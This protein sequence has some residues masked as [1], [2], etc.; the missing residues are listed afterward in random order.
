MGH[1][2]L[3]PRKPK[4]SATPQQQ[5]PPQPSPQRPA[6]PVVSAPKVRPAKGRTTSITESFLRGFWRG[7]IVFVLAGLF[8]LGAGLISM[9]VIAGP[10]PTWDKLEKDASKFQSLRILDRNGNLLSES[11]D[12]NQGRRTK[13]PLSE[14]SPYLLQ[15][16]VSTEDA[17]FYKHN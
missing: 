7:V 14:I 4:K 16:T 10:L 17:N 1:F 3:Q 12:P 2:D 13:V 5:P 8:A 15:A 6:Q 9:A 11:F